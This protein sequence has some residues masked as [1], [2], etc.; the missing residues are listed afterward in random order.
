MCE[1]SVE[2]KEK[3]GNAI[4]YI[5]DRLN[6]V[7]KTKLL[8]LLYLMEERMVE[9]YHVP[10]LALP[11][12]VWRLG[13]VQKD[14]FAELS[15]DLVLLKDYIVSYYENDHQYFKARKPFERD[16]FSDC[17]LAVMNEVMT[18]C[19]GKSAKQLVNMLHRPETLWY[20]EAEAHH[21][22]AAFEENMCNNTDIKIDFGKL[23]PDRK[24]S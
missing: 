4:I 20:K 18:T 21:V 23:L 11:Y 12:E 14:L 22:L 1:F 9:K 15:D 16:E 3:I 19:G 17:E 24:V 7:S 6:G 2:N 8:K 5:A 13:P 10:F